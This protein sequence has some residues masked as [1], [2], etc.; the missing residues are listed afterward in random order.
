MLQVINNSALEK[1]CWT[2]F[3]LWVQ[4][5]LIYL[6]AYIK[7]TSWHINSVDLKQIDC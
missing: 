1:N 2:C 6:V 3:N 4:Q 5:S 7:E